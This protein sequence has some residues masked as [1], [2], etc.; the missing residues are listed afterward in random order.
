MTELD[1]LARYARVPEE[2]AAIVVIAANEADVRLRLLRGPSVSR[3]LVRVRQ[4]IALRARVLGY[5][6][7]EIGRALN[8]DH[9]TAVNAYQRAAAA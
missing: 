9:S 2:L 8:R 5:P 1:R 7:E 6:W 3:D 4:R